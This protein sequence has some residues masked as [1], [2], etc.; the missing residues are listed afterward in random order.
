M[1]FRNSADAIGNSTMYNMSD[2]K[3]VFPMEQ[4]SSRAL[5]I[6][7]LGDG[8]R[9]FYV[10]DIVEEEIEKE[11]RVQAPR[12]VIEN[13]NEIKSNSSELIDGTDLPWTT[14]TQTIKVNRPDLTKVA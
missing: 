10:M 1:T 14:I 13:G 9:D 6:R 4:D 8:Y 5:F 3:Q 2:I 12:Q 7:E 11:V